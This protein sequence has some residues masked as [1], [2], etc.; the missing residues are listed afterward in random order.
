MECKF[1]SSLSRL[2]AIFNWLLTKKHSVNS[3]CLWCLYVNDINAVFQHPVHPPSSCR[4]MQ[5]GFGQGWFFMKLAQYLV[6]PSEPF[7]TRPSSVTLFTPCMARS[8][9]AGDTY[10]TYADADG[11]CFL[12]IR[13]YQFILTISHNSQTILYINKVTLVILVI[14]SLHKVWQCMKI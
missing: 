5:S 1:V 9:S 2:T 4:Y 14:C 12:V 7:S 13:M 8:A 11:P 6:V 10:V 3:L